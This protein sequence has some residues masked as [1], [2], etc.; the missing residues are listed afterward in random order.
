MNGEKLD[1]I[2]DKYNLSY[3]VNYLRECD[4]QCGLKGKRVIEIG[5][6]LPKELVVGCFGVKQW[7]AIEDIGY[8]NELTETGGGTQ[9]EL[10][11][12]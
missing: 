1:Q 5:G 8:W 11:K 3:H 10:N 4:N 6:S 12:P 2:R 7:I 9:P